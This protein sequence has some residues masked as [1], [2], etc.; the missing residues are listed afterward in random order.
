MLCLS[1]YKNFRIFFFLFF[2]PAIT[3]TAQ[4]TNLYNQLLKE[5]L[6]PDFMKPDIPL[7]VDSSISMTQ[8]FEDTNKNV[9]RMLYHY[10][11]EFLLP[12]EDIIH[13]KNKMPQPTS[14]ISFFYTNPKIETWANGK[15]SFSGEFAMKQTVLESKAVRGSVD[16][17]ALLF[18]AVI[19]ADKAGLI[20]LDDVNKPRESHKAKMLRTIKKDVYHIED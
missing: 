1:F 5:S 12:E 17:S 13:F 3:V 2:A 18:L 16:L 15:F 4:E 11:I 9:Y 6:K 7:Q 19:A 8:I 20:S 14:A 10:R